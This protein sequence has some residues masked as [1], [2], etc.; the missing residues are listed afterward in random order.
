[1]IEVIVRHE[2]Q[3]DVAQLFS[4]ASRWPW[5]CVGGIP[6]QAEVRVGKDVLA[7]NFEQNRAVADHRDL[8]V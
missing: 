6:V 5:P 4:R 8:H 1:M 2:N 3:I 7:S